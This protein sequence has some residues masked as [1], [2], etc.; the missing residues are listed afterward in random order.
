MRRRSI[1]EMFADAKSGASDYLNN[2]YGRFNNNRAV[3]PRKGRTMPRQSGIGTIP[4][5]VGSEA[6]NARRGG[7]SEYQIQA[8][9]AR[10]KRPGLPIAPSVRAAVEMPPIYDPMSDND[11]MARYGTAQFLNNA[12]PIDRVQLARDNNTG[13]A[14][15]SVRRNVPDNLKAMMGAVNQ[16]KERFGLPM[17]VAEKDAARMS[18]VSAVRSM[19][20]DLEIGDRGGSLPSSG[21]PLYAPDKRVSDSAAA[22]RNLYAAGSPTDKARKMPNLEQAYGSPP[23]AIERP[24]SAVRPMAA[25]RLPGRDAVMAGDMSG[26]SAE[27]LDAAA[28]KGSELDIDAPKAPPVEAPKEEP[29]A[30]DAEG[31]NIGLIRLGLQIA[32][33]ASKPGATLLG[34][35]AGGAANALEG[36]DKRD[37][38]AAERKFKKDAIKDTQDFKALEA[39]LERQFRG[40]K[41]DKELE[42][43]EE[44]LRLKSV[45]IANSFGVDN[46]R[47]AYLRDNMDKNDK[48][49]RDKLNAQIAVNDAQINYYNAKAQGETEKAQGFA[50]RTH[51]AALKFVE[52]MLP[53]ASRRD[54][55]KPE[56][57]KERL[58]QAKELY[59]Q[60]NPLARLNLVPNWENELLK[61]IGGN[62]GGGDDPR[63]TPGQE[64]TQNGIRYRVDANGTPQ[65]ID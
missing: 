18:P 35:I 16:R 46:D 5:D 51:V 14:Q 7:M 43:T 38:I 39:K 54:T 62:S 20:D 49:N 52:T 15:A 59:K 30:T 55:M 23:N 1:Q 26:A 2:A 12:P 65:P 10:A 21:R 41:S 32:K 36:K 42:Q 24:V 61:P 58:K 11:N 33:E 27:E 40:N 60:A 22:T 63:F 4:F 48:A 28:Q 57:M 6:D 44:S 29:Q 53:E 3:F 13:G 34:A 47:L 64:I 9:L 50:V 56:L 31:S 17:S 45:Q 8:M 37:L 25:G 19:E